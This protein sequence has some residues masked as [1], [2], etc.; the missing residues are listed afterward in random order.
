MFLWVNA[1]VLT[2]M[3]AIKQGDAVRAQKL[4]EGNEKLIHATDAFD[5]TLAHI[6]IQSKCL[7][8]CE[9]NFGF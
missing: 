5:S 7:S 4:L 3:T 8:L 1:R 6:A 9:K 2:W